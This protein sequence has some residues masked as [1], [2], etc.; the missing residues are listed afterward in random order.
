MYEV[1]LQMNEYTTPTGDGIGENA[2]SKKFKLLADYTSLRKVSLSQFLVIAFQS[3][4]TLYIHFR[5]G[6]IQRYW[7]RRGKPPSRRKAS[8]TLAS[9]KH[10]R[11]IRTMIARMI[12][13]IYPR[14]HFQLR[15]I[16]GDGIWRRTIWNRSIRATSCV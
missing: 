10:R 3:S 5:S 14:V 7:K 16:G 12:T 1:F 6:R 4:H 15:T 8:A 13:T 11:R 2:R 9:A